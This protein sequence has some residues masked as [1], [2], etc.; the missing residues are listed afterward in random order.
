MKRFVIIDPCYQMDLENIQRLGAIIQIPDESRL[1]V[2]GEGGNIT[3]VARGISIESINPDGICVDSGQ[4][5]V[6]E[7]DWLQKVTKDTYE[8]RLRSD[9]DVFIDER[10]E[11]LD[12]R[13]YAA[14]WY[15]LMANLTINSNGRDLVTVLQGTLWVSSTAFGDGSYPIIHGRDELTVFTQ[16]TDHEEDDEDYDS[17][18]PE[19][20]DETEAPT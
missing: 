11:C 9:A 13:E 1:R 12:P 17:Q 5:C 14:S 6:V 18:E 10:N 15:G 16:D 20:L 4:I 19:D 3:L 7:Y 2:S 8:N